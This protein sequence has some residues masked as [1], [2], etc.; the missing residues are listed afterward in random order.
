MV[1]EDWNMIPDALNAMS[2]AFWQITGKKVITGLRT[3]CST[4]FRFLW[5]WMGN[6]LCYTV[7][8]MP[9]KPSNISIP[10]TIYNIALKWSS[11]LQPRSISHLKNTGGLTDSH[12]GSVTAA[13]FP[14]SCAD[15]EVFADLEVFTVLQTP[16]GVKQPMLYTA[17]LTLQTRRS[18]QKAFH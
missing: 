17:Q 10:H 6:L 5:N 16:T 7:R 15:P 8:Q 18:L 3:H 2:R 13:Y 12:P 11:E 9:V 4:I 1:R 14:G